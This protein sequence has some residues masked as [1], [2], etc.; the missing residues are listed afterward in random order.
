M[1]SLTDQK[2]RLRKLKSGSRGPIGEQLIEQI[3]SL[4]G[5][6][7]VEF[8]NRHNQRTAAT[9]EEDSRYEPL[10][11]QLLSLY[12]SKDKLTG[13]TVRLQYVYDFWKDDKNPRGLFRRTLLKDYLAGKGKWDVILDVDK[14]AKDENQNWV[15]G[16]HKQFKHRFLFSLSMGGGDAMV[17]REFDLKTRT[18]VK[19]G[20]NL[21]F[22]KNHISWV[23]ENSVLV[24]L[25]SDP[26]EVT[27][28]GYPMTVRLWK[29]A[30]DQK[31]L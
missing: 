17:T 23:D 3:F 11:S 22:A 30:G 2:I 16:W 14:L 28:S 13:M 8:V 18:W 19:D 9:L 21:P 31:H 25:A 4:D 12:N 1:P 6:L 7:G 29:L 24:G 10:R 26:A 27:K 15:Y 5:I 20:F